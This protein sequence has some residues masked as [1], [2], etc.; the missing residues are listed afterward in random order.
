MVM[1]EFNKKKSPK[2]EVTKKAK[3][4]QT[5]VDCVAAL[6]SV[7]NFIFFFCS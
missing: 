6:I 3:I 7:L 5:I 4:H 1:N 2:K